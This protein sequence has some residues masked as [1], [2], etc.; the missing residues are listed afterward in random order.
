MNV[1]SP[2]QIVSVENPLEYHCRLW[3]Y[4]P[5]HSQLLVRVY[6]DDFLGK[7]VFFLTFETVGYWEGPVGWKGVDFSL[8][9]VEEAMGII[10]KAN[11]AVHPE[12]IG[13]FLQVH[14][15]FKIDRPDCQVCIFANRF[16]KLWEVPEMFKGISSM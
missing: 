11:F 2:Q 9:T 13:E 16:E 12:L 10:R 8:G 15:L 6:K 5:G 3:D 1:N 7:D 4:I 14:H